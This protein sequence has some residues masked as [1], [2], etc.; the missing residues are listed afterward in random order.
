ML[1]PSKKKTSFIFIASKK[2][3]SLGIGDVSSVNRR[4][5]F[6]ISSW[7]AVE[8]ATPNKK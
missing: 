6:I 8:I 5:N 1:L 4:N 7:E 3:R 2:L